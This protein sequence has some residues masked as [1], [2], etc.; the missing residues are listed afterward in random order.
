MA[1]RVARLQDLLDRLEAARARLDAAADA[2]SAVEILGELERLAQEVA[3]EVDRQRRAV[4][5]DDGSDDA[6][7]D[8]L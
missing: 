7:L 2:D 5:D 6:Q 1:D 3:A 8:L 4:A